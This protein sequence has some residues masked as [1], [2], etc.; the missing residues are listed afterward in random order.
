MEIRKLNTLRGLAALIVVISHFSNAT[1]WLSGR[2]GKGAG[3]FGVMLFF[4]LSGFLMS[5]L[6]MSKESSA[7]N[8]KNT[9][10]HGSYHSICWP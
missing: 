10:L 3:Q 5:Y 7:T 6:Y 4:I 1:N 8:I 2:L 9:R